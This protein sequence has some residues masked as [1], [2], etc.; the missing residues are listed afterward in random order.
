MRLAKLRWQPRLQRRHAQLLQKRR[1]S[2]SRMPKARAKATLDAA[3]HGEMV[4]SHKRRMAEAK[5]KIA[6]TK[7]KIAK[8]VPSVAA[9]VEQLPEL[10]PKAA[11]LQAKLEAFFRRPVG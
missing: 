7:A 9:A 4:A 6:G 11:P 10:A 5:V 2:Q 8:V 1:S 3:K